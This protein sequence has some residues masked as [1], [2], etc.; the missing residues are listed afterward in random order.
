[1]KILNKNY[2]EVYRFIE[3]SLEKKREDC[4]KYYFL[5]NEELLT[6]FS[7]NQS[8]EY[9]SKIVGKMIHGIKSIDFGSDSDEIIKIITIDN[10]QIMLKVQKNRPIKDI[11]DNIE[12]GIEEKIKFGFRVYIYLK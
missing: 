10:E 8:F 3:L 4:N 11:L 1:L 7:T 5:S 12:K 9:L 2:D 6:L